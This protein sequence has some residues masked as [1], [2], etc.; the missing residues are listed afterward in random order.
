MRP[1]VTAVYLMIRGVW[2]ICV[3]CVCADDVF[4]RSSQSVDV[5]GV[6]FFFCATL[7]TSS[8]LNVSFAET[9][10]VSGAC[11]CEKSLRKSTERPVTIA[12]H[13]SYSHL[14]SPSRIVSVS[15]FHLWRFNLDFRRILARSEMVWL[16]GARNLCWTPQ[17]VWPT[18]LLWLLPFSSGRYILA[19]LFRL[20]FLELLLL[21][22][23]YLSHC[24]WH[25]HLKMSV[26][27]SLL[28]GAS[29]LFQLCSL[30]LPPW[31]EA[32]LLRLHVTVWLVLLLVEEFRLTLPQSTRHCL[33][34]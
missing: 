1:Y 31:H 19:L 24:C 14:L 20:K 28:E 23:G 5:D 8:F 11:L 10:L 17:C 27:E 18:S 13:R 25:P 6:T 34:Q 2:K 15:Q 32:A 29:C 26:Q 4:L 16:A 21:Q 9:L 22:A 7:K 3:T 30:R 33:F 12:C